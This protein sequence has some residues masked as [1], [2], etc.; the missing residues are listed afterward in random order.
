[1]NLKAF[2]DREEDVEQTFVPMEYRRVNDTKMDF[3]PAISN[4]LFIRVTL[5]RLRT[6]KANK[7][8][9]EPLRYIM[10]TV[11][12]AEDCRQSE[13]LY[14]ADGKMDDFIRVSSQAT[15]QVV[16]LN[17][18]D[19][20]CRPS[21][22]VQITEGPFAGIKGRVKS[23]KKQTTVIG[24]NIR[25]ASC[26]LTKNMMAYTPTMVTRF[27]ITET[28]TSVNRSLIDWVYDA[29]RVT[30]EPTGISENWFWLMLSMWANTS[31]RSA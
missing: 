15:D 5:Q 27:R 22:L 12:D 19:F 7:Q 26:Q 10:R 21:A 28:M 9:Y 11:V 2:L 20:A 30:S 3:V 25:Q 24:I 16:F 13:V 1:M 6:I 23:F 17:N 31:L 29:T 18:L 14:V 8:L 4:L